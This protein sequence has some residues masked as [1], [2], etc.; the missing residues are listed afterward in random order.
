MWFLLGSLL[1]IVAYQIL[2]GR[3]LAS[4]MLVY[5][6]SKDLSPGRIQLLMI[7]LIG[8]LYFMLEV[9]HDPTKLPDVPQELLLVLGGSNVV[10]LGGKASPLLSLF[11]R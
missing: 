8:A 1:I 4:R 3:I 11:R 5:K 10:Y 9:T 7:T 6:G 2:T